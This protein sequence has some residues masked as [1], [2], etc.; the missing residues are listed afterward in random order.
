MYMNVKQIF[1][2]ILA[3]G[4]TLTNTLAQ[5]AQVEAASPVAQSVVSFTFDDSLDNTYSIAAPVLQQYGM[6]GVLYANTGYHG[7]PGYM[8]WTQVQ[9]IQNSYGWEVGGHSVTHPLMT[10]IS[11]AQLET[12]VRQSYQDLV[13]NG[14]NPVSFATPFGDY[15]NNVV[16]QI[17]KYYEAHRPFHDRQYSN[18]EPWNRYMIYLKS[19]EKST[20]TAQVKTWIQEAKQNKSW[21]VLV[22][23]SVVNG[24]AQDE[25][26]TPVAQLHEIAQYVQSNNMRVATVRDM[27][28]EQ[29]AYSN[30]VTN[31]SFEQTLS[32]GWTTDN[33]TNVTV[34]T[35]TKGSVP[36]PQRSLRLVGNSAQTHLFA[37]PI[38]V[39]PQTS[40]HL[41]TYL[42]TKQF[43]S[44]EVGFYLDEYDV[45]GNWISGKWLRGFSGAAA[46]RTVEDF[47]YVYKPTSAAVHTMGIQVYVDAGSTGTAYLD[48]VR[49]YAVYTDNTATPTPTASPTAE[50]TVEPTATP[51]ASPSPTNSPT[52]TPTATPTASPTPTIAPTSTP[53]VAPTATPSPTQTVAPTASPTPTSTPSPTPTASPTVAPTSTPTPVPTPTPIPN[54]VSN[55]SFETVLSAWAQSW[56]RNSTTIFTLNTASQGNDGT[57]SVRITSNTGTTHKHLFSDI[58]T[59]SP[60][61]SYTWKHVLKGSITSGEVGYYIDEYNTAG[62][63]ISGQWKG[64]FANNQ[65]TPQTVT[66][67][68]PTSTNVTK[69]G[70]QYYIV[71][72][73]AADLYLDSVEFTENK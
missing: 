61:K 63:W 32:T 59:I 42:D 57:N 29:K 4:L 37:Q 67:Y 5:Y 65:S 68:T 41:Y 3:I 16:A 52:E 49:L 51:T 27:L 53:T 12:E 31:S 35:T 26:D 20:T 44:G 2:I 8:T 11:A 66:A 43:T 22:F 48:N 64:M 14:I 72:G 6:K 17:A 70:L 46:D 69:I 34:D 9:D 40:Y 7:K 60:T 54:L 58:L 10:E 56:I 13:A 38:Q 62:D 47:S 73:T 18:D 36:N 23:H 33:A 39:N 28:N 50:P 71:N 30:L 19:V 55:P 24:A 25:Y 21:L 1:S 15:N 45:N